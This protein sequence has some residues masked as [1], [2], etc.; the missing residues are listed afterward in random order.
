MLAYSSSARYMTE[1]GSC[2]VSADLRQGV[3]GENALDSNAGSATAS[4]VSVRL[5][6][7][8]KGF[9]GRAIPVAAG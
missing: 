5:A 9:S 6:Y 3:T 7:S 2:N 1:S 4:S 8:G